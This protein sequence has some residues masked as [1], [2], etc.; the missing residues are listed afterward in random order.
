MS[1]SCDSYVNHLHM[2]AYVLVVHVVDDVV[3]QVVLQKTKKNR[4]QMLWKCSAPLASIWRYTAG[5]KTDT[6]HDPILNTIENVFPPFVFFF[7]PFVV[8]RAWRFEYWCIMLQ[9]EESVRKAP[10]RK[11]DTMSKDLKRNIGS[12]NEDDRLQRPNKAGVMRQVR[13]KVWHVIHS[14]RNQATFVGK[15]TSEA[16]KRTIADQELTQ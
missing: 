14:V 3:D 1:R 11:A 6:K 7:E 16:R 5:G 4:C 12:T 8:K 9:R 15:E 10:K 2:F 13:K